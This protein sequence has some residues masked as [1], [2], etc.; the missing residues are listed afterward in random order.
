MKALTIPKRSRE[1]STGSVDP[2]IALTTASPS[3]PLPFKETAPCS[4]R[5]T[6]F[7]FI[8]PDRETSAGLLL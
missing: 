5:R 1:A 8:P 6:V 4:V 7:S 2:M 3:S